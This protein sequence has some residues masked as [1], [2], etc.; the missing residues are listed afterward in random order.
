M[1]QR[2]MISSWVLHSTVSLEINETI[3]NEEKLERNFWIE[4]AKEGKIWV[5][6]R[7]KAKGI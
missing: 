7:R 6:E 3:A 5:S 4:G 1:V 2:S